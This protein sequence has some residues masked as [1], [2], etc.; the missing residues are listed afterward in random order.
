MKKEDRCH[1]ELVED[2]HLMMFTRVNWHG[3]RLLTSWKAHDL[4]S[5]THCAFHDN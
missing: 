5:K 1:H 3:F 2:T 4:G